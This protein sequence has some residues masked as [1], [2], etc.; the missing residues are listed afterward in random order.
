MKFHFG[1]CN[2]K[3]MFFFWTILKPLQVLYARINNGDHG[4][5]K[6]MK[7]DEVPD[8]EFYSYGSRNEIN[9]EKHIF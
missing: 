8:S 7:L 4:N 1:T 2:T 9:Q 5:A 3:A 6:V